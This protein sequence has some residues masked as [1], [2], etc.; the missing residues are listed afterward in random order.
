LYRGDADDCDQTDEQAVL[1]QGR[2]LLVL[3]EAIDQETQFTPLL[4][5]EQ[6]RVRPASIPIGGRAG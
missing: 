1:E 3:G 2:A 5:L 6:K 4:L